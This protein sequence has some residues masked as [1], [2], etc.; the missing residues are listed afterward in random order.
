MRRRLTSAAAL[1][2]AVGSVAAA[3]ALAAP[4]PG[5]AAKGGLVILVRHAERVQGPT[6]E[7]VPL[8]DAGRARAERLAAALA[9]A[10]V[11]A[12]FVTRFRR[13]SETAKPLADRLHLTPIEESDPAALIATLRSRGRGTVLVVGHSDTVPDVIA[14]L[15]GPAVTIA[16]DEFDDLF[17]LAPGTGALARLKY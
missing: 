7:D 8:T 5:P 2:A 12:I 6:T 14:A 13:T 3:L 4:S 9:K 11:E 16:D 1:I 17:V 15:G 10:D